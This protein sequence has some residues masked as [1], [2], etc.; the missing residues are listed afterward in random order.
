MTIRD[1]AQEAQVSVSSVS[2]YLHS[3]GMLRPEM[4]KRIREVIELHNYR[5]SHLA[6]SMRTRQTRNIALIIPSLTNLYYLDL[7]G[8]I[9]SVILK[10]GYRVGLYTTE[11]DSEALKKCLDQLPQQ[12]YD[13][14]IIAFL[15]EAD[16][17]RMLLRTQKKIPM[18][19][20]TS[21]PAQEQ[22]N[23]I[24]LDARNAMYTATAHL[25]SL[26]RH[27]LSFVGG[28]PD[29]VIAA[30]KYKGFL[31]ALTENGLTVKNENFFNGQRQH[32][33][34]GIDAIEAFRAQGIVTDGIVC[35]TDDIG[36][37]CIKQ[38]LHYQVDIPEETAVVSMNNISML[39]SYEPELT[40]IAQPL[41]KI[42]EAAVN[43][44]MENIQNKD[45]EKQRIVFQGH[46]IVR[47]SSVAG[48]CFQDM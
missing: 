12:H 42:S 22:I 14:V 20:I 45:T 26:G 46:L 34:T 9:R 10:R 32:F 13:G 28:S 27:K 40:T 5:P 23:N 21:D 33:S 47:S 37:G 35:T 18:V 17:Q 30:E 38:L 31:D 2:R 48:A 8:M 19:L 7:Y 39:Q 25:I 36:I 41:D 15:D 4:Q 6:V 16:S 24:F 1:I 11:K 3:P 29:S 44:L 43:L